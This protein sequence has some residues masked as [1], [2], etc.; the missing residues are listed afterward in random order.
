MAHVYTNPDY[1]FSPERAVRE[2]IAQRKRNSLLALGAGILFLVLFGAGVYLSYSD[3]P[4]PDAPA[5]GSLAAA[6]PQR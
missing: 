5:N 4:A 3:V 6:T 2:I 1:D